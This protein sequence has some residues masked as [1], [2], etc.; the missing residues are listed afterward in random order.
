M[1]STADLVW[2]DLRVVL[3]EEVNRLPAKYRSAF[4]LCYLEGLSNEAAARQLGC[5]KGTVLSRLSRG[6]EILRRRL[7]QRGLGL[8]MAAFAAAL[9]ADKCFANVPAALCQSTIRLGLAFAVG[10]ASGA[11]VPLNVT[12]LAEGVLKSM[13]ITQIK[14]TVAVLLVLVATG[15]GVGS[16]AFAFGRAQPSASGQQLT[17]EQAQEPAKKPAAVEQPIPAETDRPVVKYNGIGKRKPLAAGPKDD[18]LRQLQIERYNKT[19]E[20]LPSLTELVYHGSKTIERLLEAQKR[21]LESGLEV[22]DQEEDR[23]T[24]LSDYLDLAKGAEEVY[25]AQVKAGRVA[26]ADASLA[27]YHRIDAQIQLLKAKR[28]ADM[29]KKK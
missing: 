16:L 2:R 22:F 18:E 11:V 7:A 9:A 27:S 6:R 20:E 14:W 4:V 28:A 21:F 3:D 5:P 1:D 17:K 12:T 23:L 29:A 19:L 26:Q 10:V 8:S 24:L 25:L 13:F 15:S